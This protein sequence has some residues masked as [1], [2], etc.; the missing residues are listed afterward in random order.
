MNT[1]TDEMRKKMRGVGMGSKYRKINNQEKE[2]YVRKLYQ[3]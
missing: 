3:K 1:R 2:R